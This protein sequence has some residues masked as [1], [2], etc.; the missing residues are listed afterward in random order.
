MVRG[1]ERHCVLG[2]FIH[3]L[4]ANTQCRLFSGGISLKLK[5]NIYHISGHCWKDFQGEKLKV[6]VTH[7][8]GT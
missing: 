4:C 1:G 6:K 3:P 2:S 5:T 7:F 8:N